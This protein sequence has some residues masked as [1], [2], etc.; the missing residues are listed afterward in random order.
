MGTGG[1]RTA[2]AV[3]LTVLAI[4]A[5]LFTGVGQTSDDKRPELHPTT[6]LLQPASPVGQGTSVKI[7]VKLENSGA[8]TAD[9]FRVEF[10][11]RS[12][13]NEDGDAAQ[14]W[15]SF[16][17]VERS[18]LSPEAQEIELSAALDTSDPDL[19]PSPGVYEIRVLVDSN[20]QIPELDEGNN[21]LRTSV[22]ISS[23]AQGKPDLRPLSL[24]FEPPSP[25]GLSDTVAMAATVANAGDRDASPFAVS[26]AYCRL[27]EGGQACAGDYH[28][29]DRRTFS[30]GLPHGASQSIDAQFD[31][32]AL[33]L[34][35]GRYAIRI[36]V[37]PT[38]L[39]RPTGQID[40]QDE[41]NNT[42]TTGLFVQGPELAPTGLTFSPSVPHIG[43]TIKVTASVKNVGTGSATK[44]PV[45]FFIDGVQFAQPTVS[46]ADN[47]ST[48]VTAFLRTGEL[49]LSPGSHTV[50]IMIDP[51]NQIAERDET[52]NEIRTSVRLLAA[53][54]QRP[55][56]RPKRIVFSPSSPID[57]G[58]TDSVAVLGEVLNTGDVAA[59]DF[60]ISFAYRPTGNVRWLDVPCTTNCTVDELGP[61]A[62]V[63][64]KAE[65]EL[66]ALQ[67]GRYDVRVVVDPGT[68]GAANGR[69]T[70]LDEFN[71]EMQTSVTLLAA[72][73]PD[74]LIDGASVRFEPGL[75]IRYGD[76]VQLALEVVNAGQ[77]ASGPFPVEFAARRIDAQSE[78]VF[79]RRDVPALA[80]G[81]R[82]RLN[83]PFNTGDLAA[84]PGFYEIRISADPGN[85][86]AELDET[87]NVF[88][89]GTNPQTAQP[90]LVRGPDLATGGLFYD[91]SISSFDPRVTRGETVGLTL[92]VNNIG[93][94][95]SNAFRVS[96]C[97]RPLNQQNAG[98]EPFRAPRDQRDAE[99][100]GFPGLGV[101]TTVQS[102]TVLDTSDLEPGVYQ[103]L[104]QVDAEDT[105]QEENE[106]NNT[107]SQQLTIMAR[108]DLVVP[109]VSLDPPS[110]IN[111]GTTLTVFADIANLGSG[112]A[113]MPLTVGIGLRPIG[114]ADRACPVEIT[115]EVDGLAPQQQITVSA[116]F[117]ADRLAAGGGFEVCVVADTGN[118]VPEADETNNTATSRLIVG[119]SD[120]A[121]GAITF[122][123][124]PP[125]M[126]D[127]RRP[128]TVFADIGNLGEG[129]AL[130]PFAV[131]FALR[132]VSP[133]GEETFRTIAQTRLPGLNA[134]AQ[135]TVKA[136]IDAAALA[137]GAY[138]LAVTVDPDDALS[139]DRRDNNRSVT[140]F[141]LCP[142]D[143]FLKQITF[144]PQPPLAVGAD[145]L[146]LFADVR[147]L[148]DGPVIDPFDVAFELRRV[149]PTPEESFKPAGHVTIDGIEAGSQ[150]AAKIE[151]PTAELV[152][153]TYELRVTADRANAIR[154]RDEENNA[155]VVQF[156]IGPPRP[157]IADLTVVQLTVSPENA[158]A[159][160]NVQVVAEIANTGREDAGSFRAVFFWQRV[161]DARRVNFANFQINGLAAGERRTLTATLDTSILWQGTFN[162]IAIVDNTNQVHEA[163][164]ENNEATTRLN[165]SPD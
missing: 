52:N 102:H 149:S 136:T 92:D 68:E 89:T 157:Q 7:S 74:L 66:S 162:L 32:P 107:A 24:V 99:Q 15:T 159:G 95:A 16:D 22:L 31:I 139:D 85:E 106:L 29:F 44:I 62:R 112:P 11:L 145:E 154:E 2:G 96:Y 75:E 103:I 148:G 90:L 81:E 152:P 23:S 69:I 82:R 97:V 100:L 135:S 72:R 45:A 153:G 87:N 93:V 8:V 133:Q 21:E 36:S 46:L 39:E 71:N 138:E 111:P 140:R 34:T 12:R 108:P 128:I 18:G 142:P 104:A 65:L 27:A 129:P 151:I 115:R 61:G 56:L 49:N 114:A 127:D 79:A 9:A 116:R 83:V 109:R 134:D 130:D 35:S 98:C 4:G 76:S 17:V 64:A 122:D 161:N 160:R 77:S 121:V 14:S 59:R 143:L 165:V 40:E 6:L 146:K 141:T 126:D 124:E 50:R 86:I 60:Q 137:C 91:D 94:E 53:V 125:L 57:L 41:A 113:R 131:E 3:L 158:M 51:S 101:G 105:V 28:E 37:D 58:R 120:L 70:E 150:A 132:R 84:G 67:P 33:G 156:E 163:D 144:E 19:I 78:S 80:P 54:P 10:F 30:G 147:N 123:P 118:A 55:E 164:E 73:L 38:S 1:R 63:E 48:D 13:S 25:V 155:Q 47:E 20:D 88:T 42:L 119:R 5:L 117:S 26:F 43:E 110:P